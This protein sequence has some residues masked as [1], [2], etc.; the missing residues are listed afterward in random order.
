MT[1]K[2]ERLLDPHAIVVFDGAM[3]TMLYSKGVFI[4]QCYDELN[5]RAPEM[6]REIHKQY[7]DAGADVIE[8]NSFGANRIKLTQHGL[9]DQTRELN[10]AA[11]TLAREAAGDR[12]L[13]AGAVGPLGVRLEPYGPTS[14]D[15]ACA[16]F[17]EQM[18]GLIEGGVDLFIL[19]TFGDLEEIEQAIRA[20]RSVA[21]TMPIIAQMTIGA[22]GR[23]P[24]DAVV[25]P[26]YLSG[27]YAT[28]PSSTQSDFAQIAG[29]DHVY[30]THPNNVE[31][32]LLIPWLKTFVD[33]DTR[34]TQFLCPTL[35]DPG[36]ISAYRPK[37]PYVPGGTPP[38]PTGN[39][40]PLHAVGAGK[41]LNASATIQDCNGDASQVWTHTATNQ[42]TVVN[43]GSTMCLD[44]SGQGT[45]PGTRVLT[46]TC[47][48]QANQQWL[49]NANGTV[50]GVQSGL[51]LDVSGAATGNGTPV[52]LWTCN[53]QSNQQ[54]RLG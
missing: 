22:D 38:P 16:V 33:N 44:A 9:Q 18:E 23:T 17:R 42:L 47:N 10:R 20:A 46:W 4:N 54:W 43:G 25:T 31:M 35:P 1:T 21:P 41:C 53:G 6:V 15:E 52:Q 26:S 45:S 36:T 49:V 29:A 14:K 24:Y 30:Y 27:L 39:T 37:C 13:V 8:T 32:K 3:G 40:G 11:A 19:E 2:L 12:A 34:Y 48:G 51:C 7:V 5:L 50:T 28:M